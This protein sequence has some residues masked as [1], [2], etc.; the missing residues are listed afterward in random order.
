MALTKAA[1][2]KRSNSLPAVRER[3]FLRLGEN[4]ALGADDHQWI[5][6]RGNS[7]VSFVRSTK[8]I[9]VR[10][11]REKG[12][13]LSAEGLAGLDALA[14]GFAAWKAD[15]ARKGAPIAPE[16]LKPPETQLMG[17]GTGQISGDSYGIFV[18]LG[19]RCALGT[20][21]FQW[22]VFRTPH[23]GRGVEF[24]GKRWS[25]CGYVHSD[26]WALLSCIKAKSLKLSITGQAALDR[27]DDR[28]HQWRAATETNRRQPRVGISEVQNPNTASLFSRK[29]SLAIQL[30]GEPSH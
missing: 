2:L 16:A 24:E 3:I 5:L 14:D 30:A 12:I 6:Y 22:I 10:C 4:G 23:C 11:I 26:R 18:R 17:L 28:V 20:D 15:P 1:T 25:A 29:S 8:A 21:G 27:Q 13:E 7:P 9:L 19:L